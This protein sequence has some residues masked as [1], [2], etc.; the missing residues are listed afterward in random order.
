[1]IYRLFWWNKKTKKFLINPIDKKD[2]VCF[3]YAA[4]VALNH[5]EIKEDLQRLTKIK[6]FRD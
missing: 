4:T 1:M 2:N 6:T 3:Q 5:E